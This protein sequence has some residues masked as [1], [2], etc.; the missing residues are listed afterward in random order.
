MVHTFGRRAWRAGL[1]LVLLITL[2][3]VFL[4]A[5]SARQAHAS[6][7]IPLHGAMENPASRTYAC[8]IEDPENPT[9]P[10]CQAAIAAGGTQPLYDWFAVRRSDGAGRT[11]GFI[12]DGELCSAGNP[13]FLA[14]DAPRADWP[15]SRPISATAGWIG[16]ASASSASTPPSRPRRRCCMAT[17][18]LWKSIC[19]MSSSWT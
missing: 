12:P 13:E 4:V 2:V 8:F 10:A 19:Q 6:P 18:R 3:G 5:G 17:S 7:A 15:R 9:N 11:A 14:Y 16:D 1:A